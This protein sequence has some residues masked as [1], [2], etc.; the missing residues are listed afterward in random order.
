[1]RES[2]WCD[3]MLNPCCRTV[4]FLSIFFDVSSTTLE[5]SLFSVLL[6]EG[7]I[8]LFWIRRL[9]LKSY[10]TKWPS[11]SQN[12]SV[13][14]NNNPFLAN[15]TEWALSSNYSLW[16]LDILPDQLSLGSTEPSDRPSA[17]RELLHSLILPHYACCISLCCC[18]RH[19]SRRRSFPMRVLSLTLT[20]TT[21][22]GIWPSAGATKSWPNVVSLSCPCRISLCMRSDDDS[23][24]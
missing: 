4:L 6:C 20:L 7:W 3:E 2:V 1:M 15:W 11:P 10:Y 14:R 9:N 17:S 18:P 23:G 22:I 13:A 5:I 12:W 19:N 24:G 21:S 16:L 8:W